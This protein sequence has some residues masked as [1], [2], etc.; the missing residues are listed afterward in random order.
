VTV[1]AGSVPGG[2]AGTRKIEIQR[3]IISRAE[4]GGNESEFGFSS[5]SNVLLSRRGFVMQQPAIAKFA[6]RLT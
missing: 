5:T 3:E 2:N 4:R 6:T 1:T